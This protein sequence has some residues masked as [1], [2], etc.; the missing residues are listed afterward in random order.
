MRFS[1]ISLSAALL[2]SFIGSGVACAAVKNSITTGGETDTYYRVGQDLQKYVLPALDVISS[3][4]SVENVKALSKT[5]GVTFALVQSDVYKSYVN[6]AMND[7]APEVR[8]WAQDLLNSLRVIAPIYNEEI[9]FVVRKDSSMNELQDIEGHRLAIGP[10]GSGTNL[11]AKNIY[12]KLFGKAPIT[13]KP[14]IEAGVLG[15]DDTTKYAR[16]ALWRMAHPGVGPAER[17]IDVVV[18]IGGQPLPLLQKLG[19]D[20]KLLATNIKN[21]A[22]ESLLK[23]YSVGF[24]DQRNYPFLEKHMPVMMVQSYLITSEFRNAQRTAVV[25]QFAQNLCKNFEQLRQN[26]HE[27]WKSSVWSPR[28]P[29]LPSLLSGWHY[30]EETKPIL[31]HCL[32]SGSEIDASQQITPLECTMEDR[33]V[34]L[35]T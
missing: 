5:K 2:L 23:D 10:D 6:L 34:G 15:E 31:E 28:H 13:V 35:C 14:F 29:H 26:G 33:A 9:Y 16:S 27:K 32:A 8:H 19:K 7:P 18:L 21:D 17:E 12:F 11:T 4:G 25:R 24:A 1:S 3:H 22:T 20:F 30:S